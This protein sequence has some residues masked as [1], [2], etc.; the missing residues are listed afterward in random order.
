MSVIVFDGKGKKGNKTEMSGESPSQFKAGWESEWPLFI[1]LFIFQISIKSTDKRLISDKPH[2]SECIL[3]GISHNILKL[4]IN[5]KITSVTS[6]AAW[7]DVN[8]ECP[9]E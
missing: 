8:S 9:D 3:S 6:V 2:T 4:E 1:F 7:V 5:F